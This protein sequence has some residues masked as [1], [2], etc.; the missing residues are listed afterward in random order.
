MTFS[1]IFNSRRPADGLWRCLSAGRIRMDLV[2]LMV[3]SSLA[4]AR[5]VTPRRGRCPGFSSTAVVTILGGVHPQRRIDTARVWRISSAGR[6]C[7]WPEK[8]K[9]AC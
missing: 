8:A 4:A 1:M 2:G 9:R 6:C 5:V 3:L 7:A